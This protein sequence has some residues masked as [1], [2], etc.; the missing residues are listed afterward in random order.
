[1][2][3]RFL[4]PSAVV[5]ALLRGDGEDTEILLQRRKNTGFA[6]G[7]WDLSCSGHV[8]EGESMTASA[9]RECREELGIELVYDD[10]H[11]FLLIHKR[12]REFD[13]TYYNGYFVCKIFKG[14]PAVCE[15]NKCE[16]LRWFNLKKL[17]QDMIPDRKL[18]INAL[19][20]RIPY[21]EYGW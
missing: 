19:L 6:D 2:K 7:L 17:P 1:M 9:V 12:D 8:E 4:T 16:E 20:N 18:A 21:L 5:V 10:L 11:F 13:L 14:E 3:Q 15:C